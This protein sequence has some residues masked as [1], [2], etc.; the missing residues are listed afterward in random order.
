[1]NKSF[2][3]GKLFLCLGLLLAAREAA[4]QGYGAW[5]HHRNITLNTSSG[6]AGVAGN[7]DKF[8]V[9]VSL[10]SANFNFAEAKD[11]GAD[12]RF[13]TVAGA[14]LPY[15]IE[16]WDK[17]GQKAAVWVKVDVKGSDASQAISMH[18]GNAGATSE[19][20]GTKVFDK[21]D[22]WIGDWH[23][24][25]KGSVTAGAYKDATANAAHGS[26]INITG[27]ATAPGR[28]GPALSLNRANKEYVLINGSESSPLFNPL[29]TKGTFSIWANSKTHPLAYIGMFA[30]G[31]TGFRIHFY[32]TGTQTEPCIDVLGSPGYDWC[33]PSKAKHQN[34]IWYHYVI[35]IDKPGMW[36]YANGAKDNNQMDQG[37]WRTDGPEPLTIGNN[38]KTPGKNDRGRSFDGMLDEARV[39]S[40]PKDANWVK[41]DYESQREGSTFLK[42]EAVSA[43]FNAQS[44]SGFLPAGKTTLGIYDLQGRL[45][46]G[47][48]PASTGAYFFRAFPAISE[49]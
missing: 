5:G 25:E 47:F 43:V 46:S 21:A 10:T 34:N 31:E 7:V 22:G 6:G 14:A 44:F 38:E 12:L 32:G 1:M 16:S 37:T 40:V 26:G 42:F 3:I 49:K 9:P 36:Y 30:K 23:L 19:S 18:W 24:A 13:S 41:L 39:L 45:L 11:D 17:A 33:M 8:P 20:D 27:D 15:Q 35:V 48:K 4:A 2:L 29:P 28:V